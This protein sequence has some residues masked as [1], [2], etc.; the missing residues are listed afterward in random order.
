M[1]SQRKSAAVIVT[2]AYAHLWERARQR[3]YTP[4][5]V[6]ACIVSRQGLSITVDTDHPAYPATQKPVSPDDLDAEPVA[7]ES[8][9]GGPGTELKS[10]LGRI[11]ITSTENCACNAKAA[12]MDF[13]GPRWCRDNISMLVGWLREE[14]ENRGL[15][16][17]DWAAHQ[18]ILV[19]IRRAEKV[20]AQKPSSGT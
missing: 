9:P 8:D 18:L 11:G 12:V 16:F 19:A 14:A 15:P 7:E 20:A 10:L 13:H 1:L 5:E 4:R 2:C 6:D 3:G 17:F